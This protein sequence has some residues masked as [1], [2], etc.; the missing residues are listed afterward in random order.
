MPCIPMT[1]T[2]DNI[3]NH[4][5]NFS[6]NSISNI[7]HKQPMPPIVTNTNSQTTPP[8]NAQKNTPPQN[9]DN[10]KKTVTKIE[11]QSQ[12]AKEEDIMIGPGT[13]FEYSPEDP[14]AYYVAAG[15]KTLEAIADKFTTLGAEH[16]DSLIAANP[17]IAH[18][19]PDF[20]GPRAK[21]DPTGKGLMLPSWVRCEH[22]KV[23]K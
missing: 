7:S 19:F 15:D 12:P 16:V 4:P 23:K 20:F 21:Y 10:N 8:G 9:Q 11:T 6:L 13:C 14:A 2:C 1:M 18:L 22:M 5:P 17:D 3:P